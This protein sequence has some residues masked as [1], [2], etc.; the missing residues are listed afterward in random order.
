M[1]GTSDFVLRV[2]QYQTFLVMEKG[3][4]EKTIAA[5]STD[6]IRFGRFLEK[7]NDFRLRYRH[8][9]DSGLPDPFE[10]PGIGRP[11][12]RPSPG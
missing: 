5:Y 3:L 11:V 12:P 8:G 10:E 9:T 6:L 2:D 7:K 4:G 1:D